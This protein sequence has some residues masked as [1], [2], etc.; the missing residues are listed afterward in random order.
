MDAGEVHVWNVAVTLESV[1]AGVPLLNSDERARADRF[2]VEH[3]RASYTTTRG[4]LRRLAAAYLQT[5]PKLLEFQPGPFGKPFLPAF[6]RLGFN[7]S[8]SGTMAVLA[9]AWDLELGVDV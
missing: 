3:A 8:H 5:D 9:F 4:T 7:V 6:P 1:Q 2:L